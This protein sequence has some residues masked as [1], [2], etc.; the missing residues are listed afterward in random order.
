MNASRASSNQVGLD[1]TPKTEDLQRFS[2][3]T[4]GYHLGE[5]RCV[6]VHMCVLVLM[7]M[8]EG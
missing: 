6:S 7:D 3:H 2:V 1:V 5:Q 8:V 4:S